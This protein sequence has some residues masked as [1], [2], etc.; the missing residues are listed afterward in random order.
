[1]NRAQHA[2]KRRRTWYRVGLLAA[3]F[4]LFS[5]LMLLP[6]HASA[7]GGVSTLERLRLPPGA[8]RERIADRL[9]LH[10]MPAQVWVFDVPQSPS[11]L[12]RAL[13]AQ[14]PALADLHVLPG[15]L[16][17]SGRVGDDRWV[18]QM[19]RAGADRTVGSISA[20]NVRAAP[21]AHLP[22]W[23]PKGARVRADVALMEAGV[24]VSDRIWQYAL[25]PQE[26][27]ELLDAGLRRAGWTPQGD[28]ND[29]QD[30]RDARDARDAKDA[31]AARTARRPPGIGQWWRRDR[32]RMRLWLVPVD[33][34][35][36][37]RA[38]GWAP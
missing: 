12:A 31:I 2:L 25:P 29:A 36:G 6:R 23:L 24:K 1:M 27:A 19:E 7:S 4:G 16:I 10:G 26:L 33:G 21:A 37:I 32:E 34:G 22:G 17:L 38:L 8:L 9:W 15:Q 3:A 35:S 13:T 30:A 11:V 20:I 18:A 14:Q 28:A 5:V